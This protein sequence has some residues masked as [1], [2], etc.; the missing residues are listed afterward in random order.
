LKAYQL[1]VNRPDHHDPEDANPVKSRKGFIAFC[2]TNLRYETGLKAWVVLGP[3]LLG[4]LILE[5]MINASGGTIA[6]KFVLWAG[7]LAYLIIFPEVWR[8]VLRRRNSLKTLAKL[9]GTP[10]A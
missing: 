9:E 1:P 3:Y 4:A 8:R 6:A 10:T 2:E 7:F 5:G